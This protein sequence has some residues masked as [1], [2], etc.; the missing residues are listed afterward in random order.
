[1]VKLFM[2]IAIEEASVIIFVVDVTTG[3]TDLDEAVARLL[4]S[5]KKPV[6]LVANKVDNSDRQLDSAEFYSF[7]LDKLFNISILF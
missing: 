3:V 2:K 7:G 4:R 6:Y 1:M 5:T